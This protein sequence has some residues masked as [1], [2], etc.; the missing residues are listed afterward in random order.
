M[1]MRARGPRPVRA[2]GPIIIDHQTRPS[3][4]STP[5]HVLTMDAL[6]SLFVSENFSLYRS[7]IPPI[8]RHLYCFNSAFP[9]R[10]VAAVI[11]VLYVLRVLLNGGWLML[12]NFCAYF[13][14]PLGILRT[15]LKKYGKWAGK[16]DVKCIGVSLSES[17]Y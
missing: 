7:V 16:K 6:V 10:N 4:A 14:A 17:H 9:S 5:P 1:R 15:D 2:R 3:L 11:G 8:G 12:S 13:L